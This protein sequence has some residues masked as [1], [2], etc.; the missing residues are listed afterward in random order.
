M[1]KIAGSNEAVSDALSRFNQNGSYSPKTNSTPKKNEEL[2][3]QLK[4]ISP[5]VSSHHSN[6]NT[7]SIHKV[8]RFA[9]KDSLYLDMGRPEMNGKI[10]TLTSGSQN[11]SLLLQRDPSSNANLN[12]GSLSAFA[13]QG[14]LSD[15]KKSG[16]G[17]SFKVGGG[18]S[19]YKA[20]LL[21]NNLNYEETKEDP[22]PPRQELIP[23]ENNRRYSENLG[24][25]REKSPSPD[26]ED[27][28]SSE[29]PQVE[30]NVD[31]IKTGTPDKHPSKMLSASGNRRFTPFGQK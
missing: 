27:E 16:Q 12:S 17:K 10:D 23:R 15:Q 4:T 18:S 3:K 5:D 22:G 11:N 20:A 13:K 14:S 26:N 6:N 30:Y 8:D 25:G 29:D 28:I 21:K 7:S 24:K 31:K 1:H 19:F 9:E 2:L